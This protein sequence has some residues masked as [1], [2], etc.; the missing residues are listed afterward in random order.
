MRFAV[1]FKQGVQLIRG[2][3]QDLDTDGG[4]IAYYVK[5]Q[6]KCRWLRGKGTAS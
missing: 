5:K 4:V 2:G 6:G 1:Y 3:G